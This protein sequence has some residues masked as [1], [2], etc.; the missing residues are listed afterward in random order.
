MNKN[1]KWYLIFF[2]LSLVVNL[3][4]L[5][6]YYNTP[7]FDVL[8]DGYFDSASDILSGKGYI[9]IYTYQGQTY[10]HPGIWRPPGYSY[11]IAGFQ[12]IFGPSLLL[13]TLFQ[14][15]LLALFII[16]FYYAINQI[17]PKISKLATFLL[18]F[19]LPLFR[20]SIFREPGMLVGPLIFIGIYYLYK[21]KYL[22]SGLFIG[23]SILFREDA[24]LVIPFIIFYLIFERMYMIN[25]HKL[26]VTALAIL[27]LI[28]GLLL[29][30]SP[31]L[32]RNYVV[33]DKFPYISTPKA[34]LSLIA[35]IGEYDTLN[36]FNLPFF[37]QDQIR[38]EGY[39]SWF[40]NAD[41][42]DKV[43]VEKAKEIIF[44]N[45]GWY[46]GVMLKRIPQLIYFI[47]AGG[48]NLLVPVI[49]STLYGT[50]QINEIIKVI[51][52]NWRQLWFTIIAFIQISIYY[53]FFFF[54]LFYLSKHKNWAV[55]F[56]F[57]L[58][59]FAYLLNISHHVEPRYFMPALYFIIPVSAYGIYNFI[60]YLKSKYNRKRKRG[61]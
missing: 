18:I 9:D 48:D 41:K 25:K 39:E 22:L 20:L 11:L 34:G 51:L 6:I 55:L 32:I 44:E 30:L 12:L 21:K 37:D 14:I 52:N 33:Y 8:S 35:G 3:F 61:N 47:N 42:R 45:P 38:S 7:Y 17:F 50:T 49:K 4:A 2:I 23:L 58:V 60:N 10:T 15:L 5:L 53:L 36:K 29:I 57:C 59:P 26:K 24:L 43:R 31:W 19:F 54:G 13:F 1:T 28:I 46:L 40:P 27:F 16:Y 56:L